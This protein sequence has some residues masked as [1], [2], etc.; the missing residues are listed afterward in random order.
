VGRSAHI[1]RISSWLS[2]LDV[3]IYGGN[4]LGVREVTISPVY[5]H[6]AKHLLDGVREQIVAAI[7]SVPH[8]TIVDPFC[9]SGTLVAH[10]SV[11]LAADLNFAIDMPGEDIAAVHKYVTK[12]MGVE[13]A[14]VSSGDALDF[15]HSMIRRQESNGALLFLDPPRPG[16]EHYADPFTRADTDTLL[17]Y[18]LMWRGPVIIAHYYG[19]MPTLLGAGWVNHQLRFGRLVEALLDPWMPRLKP[20]ITMRG[21]IHD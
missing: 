16:S 5:V 9:G 13:L 4:H 7:N 2:G 19:D 18:A 15:I 8:T 10:D 3:Y 14:F 21:A 1:E 6:G 12:N 20:W 17:A 11:A